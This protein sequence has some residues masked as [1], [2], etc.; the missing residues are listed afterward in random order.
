MSA[1]ITNTSITPVLLELV[2]KTIET[3]VN[4]THKTYTS[5]SDSGVQPINSRGAFIPGE[6]FPNASWGGG[7]EGFTYPTAGGRV[8]QR[9]TV[10]Y[11]WFAM[12]TRFT[13]DALQVKDGVL[14]PTLPSNLA[15]DMPQFMRQCN[16]MMFNNGDGRRA[17][18]LSVSTTDVTC[19]SPMGTYKLFA[20]GYYVFINP[21]TGLARAG[22]AVQLLS[23]TATVATFAASINGAVVAGD[24]IVHAGSGQTTGMYGVEFHGLPYHVSSSVSGTY[25][26]IA[27]SALPLSFRAHD[28]DASNAKL[29]VAMIQRNIDALEFKRGNSEM[30][31][32]HYF[33]CGPTQKSAYLNLG[34]VLGPNGSTIQRAAMGDKTLNLQFSNIQYADYMFKIDADCPADQLYFIHPDLIKSYEFLPLGLE[35]KG[36]ADMQGLFRIP[37]FS[38]AGAGQWTDQVEYL[39]R[40]KKDFGSADPGLSFLIYNLATTGLATPATQ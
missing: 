9:L 19:A 26:G 33:L 21:G 11:G 32:N 28:E 35:T 34:Q 8:L 15:S 2:Q 36:G 5:F 27:R 40:V 38:S 22:G 7:S 6:T 10:T 16:I 3:Y 1:N 30:L 20:N 17:V 18:V 12:S 31:R 4:K 24:L 37:A 14:E 13:G 25:E 39:L 29:N 23:F